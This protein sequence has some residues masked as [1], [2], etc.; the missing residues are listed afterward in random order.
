VLRFLLVALGLV[1]ALFL[2]VVVLAWR[3][4]ERIVWQPPAGGAGYVPYPD[5]TVRQVTYVAEDGQRLL[6]ILVTPS[7]A[8][9][10]AAARDR[11]AAFERRTDSLA[12]EQMSARGIRVPPSSLRVMPSWNGRVLVAFH[13]NAETAAS[14]IGWAR[15]IADRTG[16][17]IFVPEYR[18]YSGLPGVP[19][20][21]GSQRDARAAYAWV[22]D[23]LGIPPERIGILGFSLGTAIATELASDVRPSVLVLEAPFTS[24]RDMARIAT[25]WPV[26]A[27]WRAIARVRFDTR[28]RVAALDVP[29]W[30]VHGDADRIIPPRMGRAVHEAARRPGELLM[31]PGAGHNDLAA[32]RRADYWS[33]L[34]RALD[35][36]ETLEAETVREARAATGR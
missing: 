13:G 21:E 26:A 16:W 25:A 10:D 14:R 31:V 33:F 4:Q 5:P 18:G 8:L 19:T 23:S 15:W 29:V 30:V 32:L 28:R 1:G 34:E 20:Y 35:V 22:R 9:L 2:T 3:Y 6:G 12:R 36:P 17:S 24:A 27:M 11:A 7:A